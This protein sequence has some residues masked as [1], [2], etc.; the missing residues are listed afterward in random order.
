MKLGLF[1]GTFDPVHYGHLLIA[2]QC[3]EQCQLDALWFLPAG[4]PPHK[5]ESHITPGKQRVDMLRFVTADEPR[6]IINEMELERE[7][8]TYTVDTL[9]AI[10]QLEPAA[11]LFFIMGAD[12]LKDLPTWKDPEI[13]ASLATI[14]VV[15]RGTEPTFSPEQ[16]TE[17]V[18]AEIAKN[19]QSVSMP[20]VDFA[21]SDIR[22]RIAQ[23]HSVRYMIPRSVEAYITEHELYK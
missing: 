11:E 8:I 17:L 18:G 13:I 16:I 15:N 21:S 12:S 22:Q 20:G 2:A 5:E 7:G 14:V 23:G 6:F 19:V 3:L 10:K 4:D 1:G 9:Q